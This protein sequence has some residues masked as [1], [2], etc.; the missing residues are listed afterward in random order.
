M[1]IEQRISQVGKNIKYIRKKR[2]LTKLELAD[3]CT[4]K[5]TRSSLVAYERG[6]SIN[7]TLTSLYAIADALEVP[8]TDLF[9]AEPQ[10]T[11]IEKRNS[12]SKQFMQPEDK[13]L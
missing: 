2:G 6:V 4:P 9:N 3:L 5:V 10:D 7:P 11:I 1:T 8:I 13:S 12:I